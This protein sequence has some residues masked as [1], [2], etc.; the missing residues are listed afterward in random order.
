MYKLKKLNKVEEVKEMLE[1][2]EISKKINGKYSYNAMNELISY[3]N[4]CKNTFISIE[5]PINLVEEL[6]NYITAYNKI[7]SVLIDD[8][9][10]HWV[11]PSEWKSGEYEEHTKAYSIT[12]R[13]IFDYI[14][15]YIN[16]QIYILI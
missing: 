9:D 11:D 1:K 16:S 2:C 13:R 4:N 3:I 10:S 8:N 12:L 14:V 15:G 7:K 5:G 6:N